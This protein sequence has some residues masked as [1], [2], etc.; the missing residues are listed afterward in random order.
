LTRSIVRPYKGIKLH[1][2]R[3]SPEKSRKSG[4]SERFQE[5]PPPRRKAVADLQALGQAELL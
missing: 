1:H 5:C 2:G 3:F 4:G